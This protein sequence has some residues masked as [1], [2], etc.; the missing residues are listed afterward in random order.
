MKEFLVNDSG[1]TYNDARLLNLFN[2]RNQVHDEVKKYVNLSSTLWKKIERYYRL[3][4]KLVHERATVGI[5]DSQIEDFRE[6][7]QKVLKK[8]FKLRFDKEQT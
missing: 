8:L 3:R 6:V 2:N 7:V 4:C 5:D 1:Q